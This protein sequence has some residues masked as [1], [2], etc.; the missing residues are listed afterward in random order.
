MEGF[1]QRSRFSMQFGLAALLEYVTVC[2]VL[3]A[4]FRVPGAAATVCLMTM[5]LALGA[6]QGFTALAMFAAALI[7]GDAHSAGIQDEGWRREVSVMLI[8]GLLVGWYLLRRRIAKNDRADRHAL[9]NGFHLTLRG[10]STN[11]IPERIS[12]TR[13]FDSLPIRASKRDLSTVKSC[14]TLTTLRFGGGESSN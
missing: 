12:S 11:S 5:A 4:L 10:S 2:A 1:S 8:G 13:F 9:L 3:W 14:E 6:R 7:A